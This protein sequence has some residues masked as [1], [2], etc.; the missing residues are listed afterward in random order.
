M[1]QRKLASAVLA[2]TLVVSLPVA[3]AVV[4]LDDSSPRER[5]ISRIVRVVRGFFGITSNSDMLKPPLPAPCAPG[6]TCP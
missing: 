2:L 6:A 3:A 4:R 5:A 1:V